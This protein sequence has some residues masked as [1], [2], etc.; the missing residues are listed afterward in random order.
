MQRIISIVIIAVTAL[1]AF[2]DDNLRLLSS[3]PAS[4]WVEAYPI[5]NSRLGAMIY[6]GIASD[7]IQ[8]NEETFWSGGP[9][10]NN[11]PAA[12]LHLDDVRGLIFAG[13]PEEAEKIIGDNFLT[14]VNG[15]RFLPIGSMRLDFPGTDG[16][17]G[18]SRVLDLNDAVATTRYTADG[19]TYTRTAFASLA[20]GVIVVHLSADRK[21]ALDFSL[22]YSCPLDAKI[23]V[24]G[25]ALTS[26]CNGV[27][28]EGIKAKLRAETQIKVKADGGKTSAADGRIHV[29]GA[30]EAT[31]YISAASNFINYNDVSGN[32]SKKAASFLA[33]AM[34]IPYG[35]LLER[36]K[37]AYREQFD[38]V[39][40][41][42]PSRAT[43]IDTRD[44][45]VNFTA[46]NDPALVALLFQYGRYLL[47]SSS[48]PGGQAANLQGVWNDRVSPPWDSKY[49]IN[50]NTEMNYWPAEVT[51]LQETHGPLF[52]LVEDL[53]ATGAET[54]RTLYGAKGW[55]AHHN[56]DLWRAAGPVDAARYGMWPNGGAWL[57][58]HLWQHYLFNADKD[59]LKRYYPV[60]KGAA[61]FYLSHLTPQPG[62]GWLV[63]APSMSPE[64]GY[65]KSWIT[66]GCTMDN[67]I[68]FDALSMALKAGEAL[69]LDD[70]AYADSLRAAIAKLPPMQVGRHG[71][72]QE[73]TVD[74]DDPAD[75]HRHVSHLYG[76]YPSN[77]ISP[78]STPEAFRGAMNTLA[79]RGDMAT[80]WSIGWKINLWAR[81]LDGNHAYAI[82][83]NLLSLLPADSVA[84]QY[85]DGRIYPNLFDAHPPFQ[86]D[87]N[88]GL[89][90]GVA[91]MLLQ[92]H[93]GALHLLPALPDVWNEGEVKGL[94]AR[95]NFD[96]D[97]KWDNGQLSQATVTSR[98]GGTLR[99]RSC[100]PLAGE[101]LREASGECPNPLF[102]RAKVKPVEISTEARRQWPVISR[103]YEYDITTVPGQTVILTR[104]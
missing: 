36:H 31:V 52:D 75:Q 94:R 45:I 85:P 82:V 73:W 5:G 38:R 51:A 97:M 74:A 58:T 65:G 4:S 63:T 101:G 37:K 10:N 84:A 62:T 32:E 90:A 12:L 80:G 1:S 35:T 20:D 53:S 70:K 93:D 39:S 54:A 9:Y 88:F 66:A 59:F 14:G 13:K 28:H 76:L 43:S 91:E 8:L 3:T 78:Y 55:V 56:T 68:A 23:T 104:K 92:S 72:L 49:T 15:M 44:R 11:N 69:G 27:D 19:V 46:D 40:L 50:I 25:N 17:T 79:Q 7:E 89:T 26:R 57:T 42:L 61:D 6:G 87:G 96:V 33:S 98:S 100:V 60:I 64:H 47:I 34:K 81:L 22:G 16:A 77:Q 95:G 102:D 18:Y 83:K 67:Q 48:Q 99:V 86:I 29:K 71:Q 103:V 41:T 24:K 2:A 30:T 21:G